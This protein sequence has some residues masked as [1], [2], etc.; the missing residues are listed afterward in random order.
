[1]A[2]LADPARPA[3]TRF[4]LGVSNAIRDLPQT[5]GIVGR[6]DQAGLDHFSV[7]DHP[8]LGRLLDAYSVIGF[9]LGRTARINGMVNVTNLPVRPAPM[10]ARAVTSLSALSGGRIVL[11]LGA[12]GSW[13]DITR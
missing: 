5:L 1:M 11:G 13:D 6:V 12:G 3:D 9:A 2:D 8:Y 4:G 10:L 7:S